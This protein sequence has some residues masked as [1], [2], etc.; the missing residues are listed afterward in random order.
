MKPLSILNK[1]IL[2]R[3]EV[4]ILI[5]ATT[6]TPAGYGIHLDTNHLNKLVSHYFSLDLK[7][8]NMTLML[9]DRII[10]SSDERALYQLFESVLKIKDQNL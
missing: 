6:I 10:K 2:N 5:G 3:K 8:D 4:E 1:P 7:F 9:Y